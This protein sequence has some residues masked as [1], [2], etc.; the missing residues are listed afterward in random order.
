MPRLVA[1]EK[2]VGRGQA[3]VGKLLNIRYTGQCV[4][5]AE[6][7]APFLRNDRKV[8]CGTSSHKMGAD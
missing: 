7:E 8:A 4:N 2:I 5:G 6:T 1:G 3:A